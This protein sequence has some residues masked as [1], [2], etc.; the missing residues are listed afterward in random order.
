MAKKTVKPKPEGRLKQGLTWRLSDPGMGLLERAGLAALYMSLRAAEELGKKDDLAP[1]TWNESDLTPESVTLRSTAD[2]KAALTKLFEWAWQVKDGVLY[3]PAVHRSFREKDNRHERV[4]HHKGILGTFLQHRTSRLAPG[5]KSELIS[6]V[7]ALED[8][9]L[10]KF[11]FQKLNFVKPHKEIERFF[12]SNGTLRENEV[13]LSSWVR[14]GM[15]NRYPTE[16][17][18]WKSTPCRGHARSAILWMLVPIV[19]FYQRIQGSHRSKKDKKTGQSDWVVGMPDVWDLDEFDFVRPHVRLDAPLTGSPAD[20][21]VQCVAA[22]WIHTVKKNIGIDFQAIWM[23]PVKYYKNQTVRKGVSESRQRE[24]RPLHVSS[25]TPRLSLI[26]QYRILQRAMGTETVPVRDTSPLRPSAYPDD[27]RPVSMIRIPTARGLIAHN[28]LNSRPWYDSLLDPPVWEIP[29]LKSAQEQRKD[30]NAKSRS[31]DKLWLNSLQSFQREQL[32]ELILD[33]EFTDKSDR[34]FIEGFWDILSAI[35]RRERRAVEKQYNAG[36][37]IPND[38]LKRASA[39]YRKHGHYDESAAGRYLKRRANW[40]DRIARKLSQAKTRR[41]TADAITEL[42]LATRNEYGS[43][44][45]RRQPQIIT[46]M[47]HEKHEWKRALD[48]ARVAL[49]SWT[50]RSQRSGHTESE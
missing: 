26:R 1:L 24:W 42:I 13:K 17:T 7:E 29:S 23:G 48:L 34:E 20:T 37:P 11:S 10:V 45:I 12:D 38:E 41:L 47:I 22:S 25:R 21:V 30:G 50:S 31:I 3:L 43:A 19:C 39:H 44:V 6:R 28:L 14:P 27:I 18:S 4:Y 8:D 40:N 15:T 16:A 9:L 33:S 2:D 36:D 46:S 49:V 35:Y 5:T 32:M